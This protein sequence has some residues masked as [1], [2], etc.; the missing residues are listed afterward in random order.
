MLQQVTNGVH[1]RMAVLFRLLVGYGRNCRDAA[2]EQTHGRG[3]TPVTPQVLIRNVLL[4][5]EGDPIDV[6][7]GD[8]Q[9][10]EIGA[11]LDA[12]DGHPR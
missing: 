10:L 6:L 9:I 8:E 2:S 5:G 4:Y 11:G 7:L 3:D 12:D 1:V